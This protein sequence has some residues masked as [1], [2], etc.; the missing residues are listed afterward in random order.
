[1]FIDIVYICLLMIFTF[2]IAL[3]IF[4]LFTTFYWNCWTLIYLEINEELIKKY[5]VVMKTAAADESNY[6]INNLL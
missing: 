4:T 5:N 1:M 6:W 2:I 3:Y